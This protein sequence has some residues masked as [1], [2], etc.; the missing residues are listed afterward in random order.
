M[1][2]IKH[3][4]MATKNFQLLFLKLPFHLPSVYGVLPIVHKRYSQ[5]MTL[6]L[7]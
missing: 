3:S 5:L 1:S 2:L 6:V 7:F 4:K